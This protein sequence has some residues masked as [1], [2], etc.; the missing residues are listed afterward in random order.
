M[1]ALRDLKIQDKS[2]KVSSIA[3]VERR[4]SSESLSSRSS[5]EGNCLEEKEM[6]SGEFSKTWTVISSPHH[7]KKEIKERAEVVAQE[8]EVEFRTIGFPI[9]V[10]GDNKLNPMKNISYNALPMFLSMANEDLDA[11]LFEFDILCRSYDYLTDEKKLKLFP[12]T[13]KSSA[14]RW[15]MGLLEGSIKTWKD[16]KKAFLGKY[17]D[18][19]CQGDLREEILHLRQG[20]DESLEDYIEKL[21]YLTKRCPQHGHEQATLKM[22]FLAGMREEYRMWLDLMSGGDVSTTPLEQIKELCLRYSKASR[23]WSI[24]TMNAPGGRREV[25]PNRHI[26]KGD[27]SNMLTTVKEDILTKVMTHLKNLSTKMEPRSTD[28]PLAIFCATC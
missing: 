24:K 14:L 16:M 10:R 12:I 20:D 11:F 8:D 7:C 25:I 2:A 21:E 13:L 28:P 4:R 26:S 17:E 23:K 22:V 19:C 3:W 9:E 27:I 1:D 18:Y 6:R 5:V 15:L